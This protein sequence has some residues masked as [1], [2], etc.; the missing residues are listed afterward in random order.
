VVPG[1]VAALEVVDDRLVGVRLADGTLVHR[2]A[3]AVGT[4]MVARTGFLAPLG[5]HAVEHPRGVGTHLPADPTGQTEVPGVWV[6]GNVSDLMAQVGAAA[7]AGALSAAAI[8][9]DL[10]LEETRRA[11]AALRSPFSNAAE[12]R[13]TELVG[14]ERRHGL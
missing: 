4:R 13:V 11:V 8:N 10:V 12:A 3:I 1:E 5:L 14:G 6:A 9:A 2:E 7:A